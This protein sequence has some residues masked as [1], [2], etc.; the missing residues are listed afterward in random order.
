MEA[1]YQYEMANWAYDT[2][3]I[4]FFYNSPETCA[5]ECARK[6]PN[7]PAAYNQCVSDCPSIRHT[8]MDEAD[9][10]MFEKALMTCTPEEPDAEAQAQSMYSACFVYDYWD[11]SVE[12]DEHWAVFDQFWACREASHIDDFQ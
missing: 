6:H 12:S 10:L 3:R 4:S 1:Y 9:A 2:A 7:D 5:E 8:E 11:Y